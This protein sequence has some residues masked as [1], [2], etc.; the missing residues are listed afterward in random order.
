MRDKLYKL[1]DHTKDNPVKPEHLPKLYADAV[2]KRR[3]AQTDNSEQLY[4]DYENAKI[5]FGF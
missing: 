5:A 1:L 2:T 4:G 3:E